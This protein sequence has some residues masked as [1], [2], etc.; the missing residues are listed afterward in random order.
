[1]GYQI[2]Q[3]IKKLNPYT[4][5]TKEKMIHL[6][7]N[8]SFIQVDQKVITKGIEKLKD[9]PLN[10]YPDPDAEE[11]C[12]AFGELYGI[13]PKLIT[14]G[15]GS[16]EL[17]GLI[18]DTFFD[19]TQKILLL[20]QDFSMYSF[21]SQ[22]F[23]KNYQ[24]FPKKEDLRIPVD[25]LIEYCNKDNIDGLIFSNPCNPTSLCLSKEEVLKIVD[26]TKALVIVDE[27]YMDFSNQSVLKE[28]NQYERLIVLKTCS[29]AIGL[30]GLRLGFAI[31][32]KELTRILKAVKSPYNV[33]SL[34]QMIGTTLLKEKE[35]INN[36]IKE[37]IQSKDQLFDLLTCFNQQHSLFEMMYPS[38]TNF[39]YLKTKNAET[40]AKQL[41]RL[42]VVA[43]SINGY[44]RITA[45]TK[46]ENQY[47][48][49]KLN[50]IVK[51]ETI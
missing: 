43:R 15:N 5:V 32:N 46:Y 44:L 7:A 40:I 39:V 1:M 19:K 23:D 37:V 28:V 41:V 24:L 14:A 12:V 48:L 8:E 22:L 3:K 30:A 34:S 10:R 42:G 33:N 35:Y 29:K 25:A 2:N 49:E 4:P 47:L 13:N 38:S 21:Y 16:D 18:I 31:A 17:I 36:A 51:E 6:D 26:S 20:E 27:A 45:G 9:Y 11:L 50:T